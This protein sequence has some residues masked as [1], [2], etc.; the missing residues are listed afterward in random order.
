MTLKAIVIAVLLGGSLLAAMKYQTIVD[1]FPIPECIN[2]EQSYK[3][4]LVLEEERKRIVKAQ[5]ELMNIST[6]TSD[7]EI[8]EYKSVQHALSA[9][10]LALDAPEDRANMAVGMCEIKTRARAVRQAKRQ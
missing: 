4:Q 8:A 5:I 9:D 1:L 6:P 7:K 3:A 2:I 10:R